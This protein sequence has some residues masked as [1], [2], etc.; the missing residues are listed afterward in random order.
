M[1]IPHLKRT[2]FIFVAV[3]QNRTTP[4]FINMENK[5]TTKANLKKAHFIS[6]TIHSSY[7]VIALELIIEVASIELSNWSEDTIHEMEYNLFNIPNE[8]FYNKISFYAVTVEIDGGDDENDYYLTLRFIFVG[9]ISL[10]EAEFIGIKFRDIIE[11][12]IHGNYI[13]K[14]NQIDEISDLVITLTPLQL[15]L[16]NPSKY[17]ILPNWLMELISEHSLKI[18]PSMFF[19]KGLHKN[20]NTSII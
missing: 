12:T 4:I 7:P 6:S 18:V 14:Y 15:Y 9:R 17:K 1:M 20:L 3:R 16:P 19:K 5:I 11:D 2:Q 13:M 10:N 8:K